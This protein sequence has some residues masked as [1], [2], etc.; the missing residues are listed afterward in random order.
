MTRVVFAKRFS[1]PRLII[2]LLSLCLFLVGCSQLIKTDP[3]QTMLSTDHA[4]QAQGALLQA[5]SQKSDGTPVYTYRAWKPEV[6][7][8]LVDGE[9]C[10]LVITNVPADSLKIVF[11][12]ERELIDPVLAGIDLLMPRSTLI[13]ATVSKGVKGKLLLEPP[14]DWGAGGGFCCPR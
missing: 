14:A 2:G 1:W 6:Q 11:E 4:P 10:L 5:V 12:K 7:L 8:E 3:K 9:R 13:R